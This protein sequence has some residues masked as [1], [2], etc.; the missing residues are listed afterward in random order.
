VWFAAPGSSGSSEAWQARLCGRWR[1]IGTPKNW[2][3]MNA[4]QRRSTSR[5]RIEADYPG[6][7]CR[8][9][10]LRQRRRGR[11]ST[12]S[13]PRSAPT[14]ADA[15]RPNRGR[16]PISGGTPTDDGLD[17]LRRL[18][19]RAALPGALPSPCA[20]T[21]CRTPTHPGQTDVVKRVH[22]SAE[23]PS[24]APF[25]GSGRSTLKSR[26]GSSLRQDHLFASTALRLRRG[27]LRSGIVPPSAAS[28]FPASLAIR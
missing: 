21:G 19:R 8:V 1:T 25:S 2:P 18:L 27:R 12:A 5:I 26:P 23:T 15:Y 28:R 20:L 7:L 16:H 4:D 17:V 13:N 9:A 22:G 6:M 24:V 14:P 10:W 3:P 11:R